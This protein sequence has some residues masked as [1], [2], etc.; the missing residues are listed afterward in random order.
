MYKRKLQ[1]DGGV[2]IADTA[3]WELIDARDRQQ[4]F[5]VIMNVFRRYPDCNH[6]AREDKDNHTVRID[7]DNIRTVNGEFLWNFLFDR[8]NIPLHSIVDIK[9]PSPL[10]MN[11]GIT[12]SVSFFRASVVKPIYEPEIE[13]LE[14]IRSIDEARIKEVMGKTFI[15]DFPPI[16]G[17]IALKIIK[18]FYNSEKLI[19]CIEVDLGV[20]KL[21]KKHGVCVVKFSNVDHLTGRF[22]RYLL[23]E[24]SQY[25]CDIRIEVDRSRTYTVSILIK[26]PRCHRQSLVFEKQNQIFEKLSRKSAKRQK[27]L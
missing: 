16:V 8:D 11:T 7:F 26:K 25:I 6:S 17:Q 23:V 19:P 15:G 1:E 9:V 14:E 21:E 22:L 10:D 18:N 27:R 3:A 20:D 4:A 13:E 2:S 5:E 24:Y 12:L